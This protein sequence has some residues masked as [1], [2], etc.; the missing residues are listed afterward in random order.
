MTAFVLS[1]SLNVAKKVEGKKVAI[2]K[3]EL[4]GK[5]DDDADDHYETEFNFEYERVMAQS[6]NVSRLFS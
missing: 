4:Q 5:D 6:T 2:R 3:F 1:C